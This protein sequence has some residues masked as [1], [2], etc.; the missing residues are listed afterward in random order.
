MS[1]APH[2]RTTKR[3]ELTGARVLIWLIAFFGIVFIVNIVMVRA[4][5]ST[6]AGL[7]T[8]SSYKAGLMFESEVA[9]AE[10][11][12]ALHWSVDGRLRHDLAGE[13]VLDVRARDAQGKPVAGLSA[14]ATLEH[15][16]DSRRDHVVH[17][18]KV[19]AGAFHG[20]AHGQVGQWDL[21]LDFYRGGERV[22]RS[23]SRVDLR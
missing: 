12:Q 9:R 23:R 14:D 16:A 2:V 17:L 5:I 8:P 3:G 20:E 19:G 18:A 11:Q 13:V 1:T 4:A 7:D 6:F 21:V 10:R 22:F 15:P